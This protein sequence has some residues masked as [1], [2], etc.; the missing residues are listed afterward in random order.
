[1]AIKMK[2]LVERSGESKSTILYYI[3]EG[4]LPEPQKPKPNVSLYD[5]KTIDL[6]RFIRYLKEHF[7]Y[8]IEQ[9][10][11]IFEHNKLELNGSFEGMVDALASIV[12]TASDKLYTKEEFLQKTGLSEEELQELIQKGWLFEPKRGFGDKEIQVAT[13]IKKAKAL[14]L[15]TTLFDT[16]VT[17]AQALAQKENE[18][19]YKL[20]EDDSTPHNER[21]LLLFDIIL[22][23]KPYIFNHHTINE[24]KRAIASK[25]N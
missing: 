15:D 1:M 2:E 24:H 23:L 13:I 10:K 14:G 11:R 22:T 20:L 12:G 7:N 6:L 21:Y 3:K 17:C 16:Y 5:E 8:S 4:L 19:G 18:V 9:I 25:E